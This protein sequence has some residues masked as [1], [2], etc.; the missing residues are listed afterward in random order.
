MLSRIMLNG[1][2]ILLL[3][4]PTNHLDLES[5]TALKHAMKEFE[6]NMMFTSHDFQ[7]NNSVATRIIDLRT[8][9]MIDKMTTF[10][11]YVKTWNAARCQPK[12]THLPKWIRLFDRSCQTPFV[13]SKKGDYGNKKAESNRIC[14]RGRP[15]GRGG[16]QVPDGCISLIFCWN[17][18]GSP[19]LYSYPEAGWDLSWRRSGGRSPIRSFTPYAI[20]AGSYMW[21][22]PTAAASG[23]GSKS[24]G[25]QGKNLT[26]SGLA[27]LIP[28]RR[29]SGSR[30]VGSKGSGRNTM[31][32]MRI[33]PIL[34]FVMIEGRRHCFF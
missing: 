4:E 32:F 33:E 21:A 12:Q 30:P 14:S 26:R 19:W 15:F 11:E 8:D 28:E 9:G 1:P 17:C 5:V 29:L 18:I 23:C 2:N 7:I 31:L 20:V 27:N 22:F 25:N 3:D 10:E 24:T 34:P 6:G 13:Y 16:P